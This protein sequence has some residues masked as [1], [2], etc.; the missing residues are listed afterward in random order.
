MITMLKQKFYTTS[1]KLKDLN[2]KL[3]INSPM[4]FII[5]IFEAIIRTCQLPFKLCM[6]CIVLF[7]SLCIYLG[8]LITKE[9]KYRSICIDM[10]REV[11]FRNWITLIKY[12]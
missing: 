7:F 5:K 6:L 8:T 10:I 1:M 2:K 9:Y 4:E 3:R 11:I 12:T